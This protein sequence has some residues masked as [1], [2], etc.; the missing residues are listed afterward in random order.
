MAITNA[1]K[2]LQATVSTGAIGIRTAASILRREG[3][4]VSVQ[5]MGMQVTR[6]GTIKMSLI[7][8]RPTETQ[9]NT[10]YAEK[11]LLSHVSELSESL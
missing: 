11:I 4:K 9:T 5:S 8:V 7:D 3:Y 1:G 10:N 6:Y 2:W